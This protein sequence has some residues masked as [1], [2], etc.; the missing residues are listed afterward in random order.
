MDAREANAKYEVSPEF[1]NPANHKDSSRRLQKTDGI[2]VSDTVPGGRGFRK[3]ASNHRAL[4]RGDNLS[5]LNVALNLDTTSTAMTAI[6]REVPWRRL[7]FGWQY[8][9]KHLP[10]EKNDEADALS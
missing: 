6:P 4:I 3:G 9:L 10:A 5:A 8:R 1:P 2:C 7:I